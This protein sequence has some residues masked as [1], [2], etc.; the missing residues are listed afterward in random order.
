MRFCQDIPWV[1]AAGG[2]QGE[3]AVWDTSESETIEKHFKGFL[4]EGSYKKEDYNINDANVAHDDEYESMS[5]DS[6]EGEKKKKKKKKD[7]KSK[8]E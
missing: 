6:D 3:L 2:S 8:K 5:D 7:K 1:L 4:K